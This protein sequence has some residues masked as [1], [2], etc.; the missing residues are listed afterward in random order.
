MMEKMQG[1]Q[2][3]RT[4]GGAEGAMVEAKERNE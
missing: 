3:D 1:W 4:G 2:K